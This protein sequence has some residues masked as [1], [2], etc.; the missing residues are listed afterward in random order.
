MR[1][2]T[3]RLPHSGQVIEHCEWLIEHYVKHD[4]YVDYDWLGS[5]DRSP[6]P[7]DHDIITCRQYKA[8][9]GMMHARSP[10]AA[11]SHWLK[12]SLPE[13]HAIPRDLDLIDGTDSEVE[14]G[15]VAFRKLICR[16]AAT[17]GLTDMAPT[18]ALHLL[19]PRFV[20]IS[21]KYVR[22]LLVI[23]ETQFPSTTDA[24]WY[25]ARAVAVQQAV[26]A[27][28]QDNAAALD[29]LHAYA[30]GELPLVMAPGSLGGRVTASDRFPVKLSKARVLDI[31]LWL[32]SAIHGPNPNPEC[33]RSYEQAFGA[34]PW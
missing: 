30:N 29:A 15:I 5:P 6:G 22:K 27:L 18:K 32:E 10:K 24:E 34:E 13:L 8:I 28:A 31:V 20:A 2:P 3:I 12:R 9:N 17:K 16:M 33:R 7:G 25:A 21:D 4:A 23:D 1:K 19:R 26:R 11:W 14:P